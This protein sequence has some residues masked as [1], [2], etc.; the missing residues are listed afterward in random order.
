LQGGPIW[1]IVSLSADLLNFIVPI[2]TNQLGKIELLHLLSSRFNNGNPAEPGAYLALPLIVVCFIYVRTHWREFSGRLL[3]DS[4]VIIIV[5][6]L[7]PVLL[8]EDKRYPI[9]MPGAILRMPLLD[10]VAPVRFCMFGLLIVAIIYALWSASIAS[11][12][13]KCGAALTVLI[14]TFPAISAKYWV[15]FQPNPE[16]FRTT[17]YRRYLNPGE[18]VMFLPFWPYNDSMLWQA[19]TGMYFRMGQGAG[20]WFG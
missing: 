16:F 10:N 19:E 12:Y 6:S 13:M 9:G 3:T 7:G 14:F 4:L 17:E 1:P 11:D 5:L 20:P 8:I 15:R 2:D 18:T